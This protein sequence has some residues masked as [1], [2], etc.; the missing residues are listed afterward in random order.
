MDTS[1]PFQFQVTDG[2]GAPNAAHTK[3]TVLWVV[4]DASSGYARMTGGIAVEEKR[5]SWCF[6]IGV[7][8]LKELCIYNIL[9]AQENL[10]F[11]C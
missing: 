9:K 7:G 6:Q 5:N 3:L 1:L 4:A 8:I 10:G 2:D 11:A